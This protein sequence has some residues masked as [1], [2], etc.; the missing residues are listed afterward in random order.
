MQPRMTEALDGFVEQGDVTQRVAVIGAGLAGLACARVLRRAGCYVEIFERE[1]V[2]GG[3]MAMTRLGTTPF[4]LGCQYLTARS[5]RFKSFLAELQAAGYV[6]TWQPKTLS[7]EDGGGQGTPWLVGSPSM[8]AVVRP[9]AE[10]VRINTG[11]NA[12]T[13]QRVEKAWYIW[14]DDQTSAGPFAAIAIATPAPDAR[15]LL[16]RLD[17]LAD[18][19]SRVRMSP[20]WSMV[21]RVDGQLLPGQD[22]YSDMSQVIRWAA[23]N[24]S[25]PGRPRGGEAIVIQAAQG[26]SRETEDAD[27]QAVAEELWAELSHIFSLPP[28]RPA[29]MQAHLWRNALTDSALSETYLFSREHMVGVCGDWCLGRLAEHAYESGTQLGSTIVGSF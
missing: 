1:R 22:V 7:R 16:G 23:R 27:P 25:K 19:L 18:S 13:I 5:T 24:N 12:H 28:V 4:D 17:A 8:P 6:A 29:E 26:W 2:I 15:L 10:S 20:C 14:F 21:A 9:L 11:R 3:R